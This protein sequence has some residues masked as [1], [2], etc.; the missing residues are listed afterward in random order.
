MKKTGSSI[1]FILKLGGHA[2][3]GKM[4]VGRM[5]IIST[6]SNPGGGDRPIAPATRVR[7]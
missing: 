4:R 3:M 1:P 6:D 7:A 5:K 2:R